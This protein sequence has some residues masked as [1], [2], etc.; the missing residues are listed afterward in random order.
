MAKQAFPIILNVFCVLFLVVF[1]DLITL[2]NSSF[3]FNV[4]HVHVCVRE[5]EGDR[6]T[7]IEETI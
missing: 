6:K 5:T 2:I 4:V 3:F 1:I 7:E